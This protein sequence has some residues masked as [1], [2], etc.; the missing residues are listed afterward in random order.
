MFFF[1]GHFEIGVGHLTQNFIQIAQTRR[2]DELEGQTRYQTKGFFLL[3]KP[4]LTPFLSPTGWIHARSA[5]KKSKKLKKITTY[6]KAEQSSN[7]QGTNLLSSVAVT[8][9][10]NFTWQLTM[11]RVVT[12]DNL[13]SPLAIGVFYKDIKIHNARMV[14][15]MWHLHEM[16][17]SPRFIHE[18]SHEYCHIA[19]APVTH[20]QVTQSLRIHLQDA[21]RYHIPPLSKML[22]RPLMSW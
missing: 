18:L 3:Y 6:K 2:T 9:W 19:S 11:C 10:C 22:R 21:D 7:K 12:F 14:S 15:G 13:S 20:V 17:S 16:K 1:F 5:E 4:S 8:T